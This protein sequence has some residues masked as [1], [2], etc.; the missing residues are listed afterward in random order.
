MPD[1][2]G[3][4]SYL[5][6][7][8][9]TNFPHTDDSIPSPFSQ[10]PINLSPTSINLS[11][12]ETVPETQPP[13]DGNSQHRSHLWETISKAFHKEMEREV[14]RE[15]DSL[16]SKWTKISGQ[17]TKFTGF[18]HKAKQNP[19]S[20]ETEADFV[21]NALV[22]YKTNVGS[23]FRFMHCWDICKFHPKRA[24]IPSGSETNTSSKR[25]R[26]P[27]SQ[28][29]SD[30]QD[31]E[32]EDFLDD[33]PNRP[34]Y[35]R[36]AA[37]RHA[38]KSRSGTTSPSVG[39]S[40][41]RRGVYSDQLDDIATNAYSIWKELEAKS[42]GNEDLLR[43][44]VSLMKKEF[45][46]FRG[47]RTEN[48]KQII[49]RYCNLVKNMTRLGIH[50]SKD[51]L[52]EKLADALPHDAPH[53]AQIAH[54]RNVIKDSKRACLVNQ[55]KESGFSWDKYIPTD[56]KVCL[57]DQDDEKLAE[58]FSWDNYCPDQEFM[59]KEMSN[60]KAFVANAYD[61]YWAEKYRKIRQAEEEKWKRYEKEEEEER[62]KAEAEN[63]KREEEVQVRTVK[64][65]PEFEI[66]ADT[67]AVKV[68]E[69]CLNC[70][71]LI[72]QNNELLHNIKRLKESYDTLNREMN[73]YTESNSEQ[74]VAMNTLKGAYMR[75]L[76]DV[77]YYTEKIY[78]IV[79]RLKTFEEEKTSE[80]KKYETKE[81]D[82]V[83]ISGKS[84]EDE[85]EQAFWKQTNQEFLAKKQEEVKKKVVQKK[86][87]TRTCF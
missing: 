30:A 32:L 35:G 60:V 37:K 76:D 85:K 20:G 29:Q 49:E 53:Q 56:S 44:K 48:T 58:G 15:N 17:L 54:G 10:T 84:S 38:Q 1:V 7:R 8:V 71:S 39:S 47:L 45:D 65:V 3:Y 4:A 52:I 70:D 75:Q 41:S 81:E 9:N 57:A 69:K 68:P 83:E 62:R 46:L 16:S 77:N 21:T 74:A 18:L 25:S 12:T 78:P 66:K 34:E 23:D 5:S 55:G 28:A 79:E 22:T 51:E 11:Q 67:E 6:N 86:T 43:N 82:E 87:E 31:Q 40:G 61:E 63:K 24:N 26:T 42:L 73:K 64:E 59:A 72:K 80:E 19:K 13:I 27:S 36:D 33:S 50:K 2:A 14:Y